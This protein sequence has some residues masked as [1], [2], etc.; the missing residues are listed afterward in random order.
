MIKPGIKTLCL[1]TWLICNMASFS[2]LAISRQE[3]DEKPLRNITSTVQRVLKKNWKVERAVVSD[4]E[5]YKCYLIKIV[6]PTKTFVEERAGK[7]GTREKISYNPSYTLFFVPL[8][9]N[10]PAVEIREALK[11]A[12]NS[13]RQVPVSDFYGASDT[14]VLLYE[15]SDQT[16]W[17]G[18][19]KVIADAFQIAEDLQDDR[20]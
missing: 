13:P 2:A 1:S 3:L 5:G 14:H 10:P 19:L 9:H 11:R 17:R 7:S 15:Q 12:R 20:Q 6:D 18:G 16:N 4:N 8:S